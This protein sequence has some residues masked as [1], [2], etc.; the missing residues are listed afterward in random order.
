MRIGPLLV[1]MAALL[2]CF[3]NCGK[4]GNSGALSD[5]SNSS[6]SSIPLGYSNSGTTVPPASQIVDA[7][8]NTWTLNAGVVSKNSVTVTSS[9]V[10]TLLL[11]YNN[12]VYE[13]NTNAQWYLWVNNSWTLGVG[14]PRVPSS[15]PT[16]SP[17]PVPS[18]T[19]AP[20]PV[21]TATPGSASGTTIPSA[22]EI[23]D[24]ELNVWTVTSGV[25]YE[26]GTTVGF[27]DGVILL[28]YYNGLFYQEN[29][30]S[31]WWVWSGTTW[32]S[33]SDPR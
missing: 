20:T 10:V 24:S 33:S 32:V 30:H 22:T 23:L 1:I 26:N 14:D 19:A 3:Q 31:D 11:Y 25:V 2:L 16:P 12:L 27:S 21:P 8:Q 18:P 17:T 6:A 7:Q 28:L 5:Q 29:V 4:L 13:Q 15:T 9:G